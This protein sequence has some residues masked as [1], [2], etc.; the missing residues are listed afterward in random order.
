M[1]TSA[2]PPAG[3]RPPAG[4]GPPTAQ[5]SPTT[6]RRLRL[7]LTAGLFAVATVAGV[8]VDLQGAAVSPVAPAATAALGAPSPTAPVVG[9]LHGTPPVHRGHR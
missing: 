8:S 6:R 4:S 9:E 7:S 1:S 5:L 2:A 3:Y